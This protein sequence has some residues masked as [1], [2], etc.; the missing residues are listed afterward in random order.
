MKCILGC[1]VF[2]DSSF[3]WL[4]FRVA[5]KV[6]SLSI[7]EKRPVL[8]F[9]PGRK[10]AKSDSKMARRFLEQFKKSLVEVMT[11]TFV[12]KR[13]IVVNFSTNSKIAAET[14]KLVFDALGPFENVSVSEFPL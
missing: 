9:G 3:A 12:S 11:L 8:N 7:C 6:G 14:I 2:V 5:K 1:I 4:K 13:Q 10:D